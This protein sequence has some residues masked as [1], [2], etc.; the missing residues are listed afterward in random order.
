MGLVE[1][2]GL[3]TVQ[4]ALDWILWGGDMTDDE[5]LELVDKLENERWEDFYKYDD[6]LIT[7]EIIERCQRIRANLQ[8]QMGCDCKY[9]EGC[10]KLDA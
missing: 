2:D 8:N 9:G 1:Q 7:L 6:F 5:K 4:V 3:D 10:M